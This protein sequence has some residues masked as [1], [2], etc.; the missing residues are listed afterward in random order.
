MLGTNANAA[1][2]ENRVDKKTYKYITY[3][4]SSTGRYVGASEAAK[5]DKGSGCPSNPKSLPGQDQAGTALRA[6]QHV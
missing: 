3:L 2:S 5:G 1:E 4:F 6:R